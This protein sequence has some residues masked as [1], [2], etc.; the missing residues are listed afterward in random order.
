MPNNINNIKIVK[1][2]LTAKRRVI[3]GNCYHKANDGTKAD[4]PVPTHIRVSEISTKNRH[5]IGCC[6][7]Q[8]QHIGCTGYLHTKLSCQI[9]YHVW[10][11][12]KTC[13]TLK[14]L[15]SCPTHTHT[16]TQ[17]IKKTTTTT[18]K[19]ERE[20]R[21][22]KKTPYMFI[23]L[24][25]YCVVFACVYAWYERNLWLWRGTYDERQG[26]EATLGLVSVKQWLFDH[27][28]LI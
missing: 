3:L 9:K 11:Q 18:Y 1:I 19:L 20:R 14:C 21:K 25:G 17:N 12:P 13:H 6:R 28:F 8:E 22:E 15:I 4:H 16:R 10:P 23:C 5:E 7:P 2:V 26:F 24:H 27:I